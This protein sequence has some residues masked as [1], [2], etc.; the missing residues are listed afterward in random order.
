M[1]HVEAAPNVAKLNACLA[2]LFPQLGLPRP[3]ETWCGRGA[4]ALDHFRAFMCLHPACSRVL[5][6]AAAARVARWFGYTIIRLAPS[7]LPQ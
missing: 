2:R 3:A 4:M 5:V 7:R 1:S 6:I